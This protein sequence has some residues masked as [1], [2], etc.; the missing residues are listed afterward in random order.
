[1]KPLMK[2]TILGAGSLGSAF[3]GL[4]AKAGHEVTLVNHNRGF[5]DAV[6]SA[7]LVMVLGGQDEKVSLRA[8]QTA[9]SLEPVDLIIVLVKSKDTAT[10][11]RSAQ[12]II[13]PKTIVM[14][15]QNG[16]GHEDILSEAIGASHIIAGKT[17]V[18][19]QLTAPGRVVVGVAGKETIIGELDG[20]LSRRVTEIAE[21]FT[22]AGLTTVVSDDITAAMWDKLLV[23][24]ATGALSGITGLDYGN[25]Y[26]VPELRATAVA[27]VE[28]AMAVARA[29][30]V[31]LKTTRAEDPWFKAG[32]GL[33]F[34]FKASVLQ[35]LEK[36][37]ITEVDF[38]NGT[39]VRDGAR[40]GIATPVNAT[41]VACI[42]GVERA[43][44]PL[45]EQQS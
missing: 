1:M 25:L 16:I 5:C 41:L 32:T 43:L 2:I 30:G 39:V 8:A 10:V 45:T 20:T 28:E 21:A 33:P 38:I 11:I 13:A 29:K 27:A 36:G 14:S 15:L 23:N 26:S 17:Y 42:K 40:L 7:G 9:D 3:G 24:V 6:N 12:H 18:G 37:S 19:G 22:A 44:A 34:A 4:L 31:H 35:S